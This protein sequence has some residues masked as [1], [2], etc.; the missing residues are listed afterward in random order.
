MT[1]RL[2]LVLGLVIA[3]PPGA[4]AQSPPTTIEYYHLDGVGSVRAVSNETGQVVRKHNYAPFGE[5]HLAQGGN[6]SRGFV[7]KERDAETGFDYFGARYYG[8]RTGRFTSADTPAADV[9]PAKPQSWNRYAYSRNNPLR[10]VDPTGRAIQLLGQTESDRERE[11]D[12]IRASLVGSELAGR[13]RIVSDGGR[14][15]VHIDGDVKSFAAGGALEAS[16]AAVISDQKI[17]QFSLGTYTRWYDSRDPSW[18]RAIPLIGHRGGYVS[19]SWSGGVTHGAAASLTGFIQTVIDPA[20]LSD[21]SARAQGIPIA[22]LGETVAHEVM[23][24]GRAFMQG[25]LSATDPHHLKMAIE[26]EN[27]AR[28]RGGPSRGAKVRH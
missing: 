8:Q 27:A 13:L 10:Y 15:F 25:F 16:L 11:L 6:D 28:A 4:R 14:Y 3:L 9:D 23:G 5:E 7:G 26:A 12:A 22:T 17:L 18:W 19:R 2:L 24:H 1:R 20:G 21:P